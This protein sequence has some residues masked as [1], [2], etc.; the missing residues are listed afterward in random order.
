VHHGPGATVAT[1]RKPRPGLKLDAVRTLVSYLSVATDRKPRPGLKLLTG[2]LS[3][4]GTQRVATDR[5]PRPGLKRST[6]V[7]HSDLGNSRDGPKTQ[8]G[9]E[10]SHS[11][12]RRREQGRDGPKTQTGIETSSTGELWPQRR[13]VATDRKPRPGLKHTPLC[14]MYRQT[15][16]A[17]DRK[18]RPGLKLGHALSTCRNSWRRDGPKTQT[19]IET[20]LPLSSA[21][22]CTVCRDGPKTQ[23]GIETLAEDDVHLGVPDVATDRKPRPGLKPISVPI[24]VG[25]SLASRRTE[26]P[27]RD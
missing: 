8:T 7:V 27:D 6:G 13:S 17:T 4:P 10:T 15:A 24:I 22:I 1:D 26:N 2:H 20:W 16:V 11:R 9:I 5:K 19:G 3:L 23:T 14:R 21:S 25:D 12:I 18:P